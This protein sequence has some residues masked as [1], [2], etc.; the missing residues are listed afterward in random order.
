[1]TGLPLP[2]TGLSTAFKVLELRGNESQ[3]EIRLAYLKLSKK[4]HPDKHNAENKEDVQE[5]FKRLNESYKELIGDKP[6]AKGPAFSRCAHCLCNF[7]HTAYLH[8]AFMLSEKEF[9][10]ILHLEYFVST[11]QQKNGQ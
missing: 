8:A 6:K 1:M 4:L 5:Q 11:W 10:C 9:C 3:H 7:Q 2:T